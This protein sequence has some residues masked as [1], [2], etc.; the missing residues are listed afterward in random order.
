MSPDHLVPAGDSQGERRTK[1]KWV[2]FRKL[3]AKG[4]IYAEFISVEDLRAKA[5]RSLHELQ[6]VLNG[7]KTPFFRADEVT[8]DAGRLGQDGR[9][10]PAVRGN[11]GHGKEHA[12]LALGAYPGRESP[13]GLGGTVLVQLLRARRRHGRLLH[14]CFGIHNGGFESRTRGEG[15]FG[16]RAV[17]RCCPR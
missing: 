10:G 13:R 15:S 8:S 1:A 6:K 12:H 11:R 14:L 2:A 5:E 4:R 3:A 9:S 7:A 17:R 16:S